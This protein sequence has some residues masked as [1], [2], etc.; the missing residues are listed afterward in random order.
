MGPTERVCTYTIEQNGK[1]ILRLTKETN[2]IETLYNS[3][4]ING[5][6]VMGKDSFARNDELFAELLDLYTKQ[7]GRQPV[8]QSEKNRVYQMIQNAL[9]GNVRG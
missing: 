5:V 9:S 6:F 2:S 8:L 3:L 7:Q 1:E 4:Y